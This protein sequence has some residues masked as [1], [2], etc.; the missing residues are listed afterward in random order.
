LLFDEVDAGVGGKVAEIVGK[1]LK[2]VAAHHQ[3]ISVT[4]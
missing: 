1:K 3:V 4:H 2:Q